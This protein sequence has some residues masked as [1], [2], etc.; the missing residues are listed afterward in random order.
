[1]MFVGARKDAFLP[2]DAMVALY[3]LSSC[4][5]LS[6]R[7]SQLGTVAKRLNVESR[8]Q[9]HTITRDSGCLLPKSMRNSNGITHNGGAK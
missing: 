6:V 9:R 3:M 8:E 2:R 7:L 5:R 4:V 1:M